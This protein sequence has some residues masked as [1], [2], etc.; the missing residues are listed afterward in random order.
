[1]IN[2]HFRPD[3]AVGGNDCPFADKTTGA[4]LDTRTNYCIFTD[5]NIRPKLGCWV[6]LRRA[7]DNCRRMNTNRHG[8]CGIKQLG[9]FGKG[10][11]RIFNYECSNRAKLQI[12]GFD[13]HG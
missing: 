1:M 4:N 3:F 2:S 8:G 10:N 9:Y 12:F 11:I 13:Q 7:I 5:N 6:Y